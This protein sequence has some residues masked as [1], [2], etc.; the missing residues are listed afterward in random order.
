MYTH[1][2]AC[3][4]LLRGVLTELFPWRDDLDRPGYQRQD[5]QLAV[6]CPWCR[7][8]HYHGWDPANDGR[9]AE[10]RSAHCH[11]EDSPFHKT[12]YHISVLRRCDP[13][14]S[15]HVVT[16]GCEIVRPIPEWE[17]KRR[18]AREA[19]ALIAATHSHADE[20][21]PNETANGTH[22]TAE[23]AGGRLPGPA[24]QVPAPCREV[25]FR[26]FRTNRVLIRTTTTQTEVTRNE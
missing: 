12:G 6:W 8:W 26:H 10:H 14:Y 5:A 3:R 21:G 15:A 9:H 19:R 1:N 16:P 22:G 18:A 23:A 7:A 17:L 24:G 25:H 11:D 13:G 2:K 4:P 20:R